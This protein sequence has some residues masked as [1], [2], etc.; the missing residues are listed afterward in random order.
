MKLV[1]LMYLETDEKCVKNFARR[2]EDTGVHATP[3]RRGGGWRGERLVR[4]SGAL[5]VG[6]DHDF[7]R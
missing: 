6:C 4:D 7:S 3:G 5:P 1:I 2:P